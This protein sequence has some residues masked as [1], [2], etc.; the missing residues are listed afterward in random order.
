MAVAAASN[1]WFSKLQGLVM[2]K[3]TL[4]ETYEEPAM[5]VPR[6]RPAGGTINDRIET[7]MFRRTLT[8]S[9]PIIFNGLVVERTARCNARCAMCYQG[10]G[11]KGSDAIGNVSLDVATLAPAIRDAAE[12]AE[13][14]PR[15]HLTGGEAFLQVDECLELFEIARDAGFLEITS[16]TNA[17]W[18]RNQEQAEYMCANLAKAGVTGLEVSWDIW[19]LP[20]ISHEVVENCLLAARKYDIDVNLRLLTTPSHTI[21]EALDLLSDEAVAA[22]HRITSGPVFPSGR[23]SKTLDREDLFVQGTLDDNCHS[24]L[25]LTI[26]ANGRVSP[27]CAGVDQTDGLR[28]GDIKTERLSAIVKRM[29]KSAMVKALVFEGI[30]SFI[31]ILERAGFKSAEGGY[32]SICH[33]CWTIFSDPERSAAI[34][35]HFGSEEIEH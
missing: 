1:F 27:C 13:L 22:A 26:S 30:G 20:F 3:I 23:A 15:F 5:P 16:T 9:M 10:A 18:A 11:P 8:R 31:P 6:I 12:L 24:S 4:K 2:M 28:L 33:M 34:R 25:N 35:S 19:H 21:Q 14:H 32:T 7:A 29:Q 17:Y